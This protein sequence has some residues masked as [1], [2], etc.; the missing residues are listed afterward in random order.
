[1][2]ILSTRL[3]HLRFGYIATWNVDG[4]ASNVNVIEQM[5]VH[6]VVVRL[7]RVVSDRIVLV[8]VVR[9]DIGKRYTSLLHSDKWISVELMPL[10]HEHCPPINGAPC[11]VIQDGGT[12]AQV[13]HRLPDRVQHLLSSSST[14]QQASEQ[15]HQRLPLVFGTLPHRLH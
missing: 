1:M 10:Q 15:P 11:A 8:E 3:I 4:I 13:L 14:M 5:V 12:M 7:W 6:K 2:L 9:L